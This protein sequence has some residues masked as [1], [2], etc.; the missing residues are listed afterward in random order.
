MKI[1]AR[2]LPVPQELLS[3]NY[4]EDPEHR[5]RVQSWV[6]SLWQEKD[7]ALAG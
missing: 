4:A 7:K 2:V 1:H 6:T 3:G 5:A